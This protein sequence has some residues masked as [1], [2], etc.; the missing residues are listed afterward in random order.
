MTLRIPMHP[1]QLP[2]QRI[3]EVV[4]LP[5]CPPMFQASCLMPFGSR[6]DRNDYDW[7]I[8]EGD[9]PQRFPGAAIYVAQVEW[10]E[11][12]NH[13]RLDAYYI[14][15]SRSRTHWFLW[16]RAPDDNAWQV[17]VNSLLYVYCQRGTIDRK[18]AAI[19]LLHHAW[20]YEAAESRRG[21]FDWI[22]G[23]GLLTVAEIQA[24][25]AAVWTEEG[26]CSGQS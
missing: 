19:H 11:D 3:L 16:L 7:S 12:P 18:T 10:A 17:R 1:D 23:E 14:C 8:A 4:S 15:S 26:D 24:I 20:R 25:A 22:N 21:R 13:T 2:Q 9:L 5:A 6:T